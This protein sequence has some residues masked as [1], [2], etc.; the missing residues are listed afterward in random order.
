[1]KVCT[2]CNQTKSENEFH[3]D[4]S[5]KDGM[6]ALCKSCKVEIMKDYR[7][8]NRNNINKYSRSYRDNNKEKYDTANKNWKKRT[9]YRKK[10]YEKY[11]SKILE[12]PSHAKKILV[13]MGIK[14]PPPDLIR[15]KTKHL[16]LNRTLQ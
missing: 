6:Q 13:A 4:S 12:F 8:N 10:Y 15:L 11:N 9:G 16:K 1:M 2:R 14:N 3:K 5:K 7:K